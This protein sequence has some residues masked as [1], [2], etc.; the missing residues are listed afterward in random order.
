M[1]SRKLYGIDWSAALEPKRN[2]MGRKRGGECPPLVMKGPT[3]ETRKAE[4]FEQKVGLEHEI[5]CSPNDI[6]EKF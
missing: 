2:Q 1:Q 3:R 6:D 4:E 5:G